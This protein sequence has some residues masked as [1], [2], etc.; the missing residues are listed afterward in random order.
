MYSSVKK[1][2]TKQKSQTVKISTSLNPYSS[3]RCRISRVFGMPFLSFQ[4]CKKREM[5]PKK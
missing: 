3:W 5:P 1:N 4:R 2:A